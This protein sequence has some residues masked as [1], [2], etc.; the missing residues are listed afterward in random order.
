MSDEESTITEDEI[1]DEQFDIMVLGTFKLGYVIAVSNEVRHQ[2]GPDFWKKEG[3]AE[4][5]IGLKKF[6]CRVQNVLSQPTIK[7]VTELADYHKTLLHYDK[8]QPLITD[9]LKKQ[10]MNSTK[11]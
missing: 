8:N 5:L 6:Y 9:L 7:D 1:T 10:S 2:F 11:A 3:S 4:Q